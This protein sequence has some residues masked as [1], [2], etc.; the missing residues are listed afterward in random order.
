MNEVGVDFCELTKSWG[1][2]TLDIVR[3]ADA[4]GQYL[5]KYEIEGIINANILDDIMYYVHLLHEIY[6]I[7]AEYFR[8]LCLSGQLLK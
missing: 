4:V 3:N 7:S 2:S 6:S 1:Y 5:Y 8:F